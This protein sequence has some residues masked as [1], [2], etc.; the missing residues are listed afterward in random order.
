[1]TQI[2]YFSLTT[3]VCAL[4]F[5]YCPTSAHRSIHVAVGASWIQLHVEIVILTL[6]WKLVLRFDH[7]IPH[8]QLPNVKIPC[9]FTLEIQTMSNV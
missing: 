5:N 6:K 1:M 3:T 8:L 7:I 9:G 2:L 4:G